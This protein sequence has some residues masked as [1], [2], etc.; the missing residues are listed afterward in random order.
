MSCWHLT[1]FMYSANCQKYSAARAKT[2][3][4]HLSCTRY[5]G[6]WFRS[7]KYAYESEYI[8][9]GKWMVS[10]E[11]HWVHAVTGLGDCWWLEHASKHSGPAPTCLCSEDEAGL[12]RIAFYSQS[13]LIGCLRRKK[14][15]LANRALYIA[16]SLDLASV[17]I[18]RIHDN[19]VTVLSS[20]CYGFYTSS[21]ITWN[22]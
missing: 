1:S 21:M 16:T 5:P 10:F 17:P 22:I 7:R 11:S 15:N 14:T 20:N 2:L 4:F 19:S 9:K 3:A 13:L 8:Y 12:C 18:T 6:R